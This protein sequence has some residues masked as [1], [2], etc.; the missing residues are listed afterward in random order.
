MTWTAQGWSR[1]YR[2]HKL[3]GRGGRGKRDG[4]VGVE[5]VC[6]FWK[7]QDGETGEEGWGLTVQE[8]TNLDQMQSLTFVCRPA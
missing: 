2:V 6:V 3:T 4:S 1:S 7:G 8:L 5:D